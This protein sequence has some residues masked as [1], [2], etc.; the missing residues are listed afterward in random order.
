MMSMVD[1]VNLKELR[2]YMLF[3]FN[4]VRPRGGGGKGYSVRCWLGV[5]HR[6]TEILTKYQRDT[7]TQLIDGNTTPG[8]NCAAFFDHFF[9]GVFGQ[10]RRY[11]DRLRCIAFC[12]LLRTAFS[13]V[14]LCCCDVMLFVVICLLLVSL[15]C[16]LKI[17][18]FLLF[19]CTTRRNN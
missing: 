6:D 4:C 9:R 2:W 14:V 15:V 12:C 17:S 10:A 18:V 3:V 7:S 8:L 1:A 13:C 16:W 19:H 5:C 11:L